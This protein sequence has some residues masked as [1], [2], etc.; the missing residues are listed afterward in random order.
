MRCF[1]VFEGLLDRESVPAARH[2]VLFR[3]VSA[4]EVVV[5]FSRCVTV[6]AVTRVTLLVPGLLYTTHVIPCP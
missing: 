2:A 1:V 4:G 6:S 5:L 3:R